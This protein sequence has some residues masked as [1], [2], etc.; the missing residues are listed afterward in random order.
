MHDKMNKKN[1][2]PFHFDTISI[3]SKESIINC[4]RTKCHFETM[5]PFNGFES[6][7]VQKICLIAIKEVHMK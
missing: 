2:M 4:T 1:G 6:N 5:E 3:C 7:K